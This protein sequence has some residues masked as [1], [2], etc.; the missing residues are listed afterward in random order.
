MTKEIMLILYK[1]K[2]PIREYYKNLYA[3]NLDQL[4]EMDKFL[5]RDNLLKLTQED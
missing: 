2:I 4:G 1:K 3:K 5:E